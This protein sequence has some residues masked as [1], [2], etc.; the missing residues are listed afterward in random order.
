MSESK[1]K[2]SKSELIVVE[3]IEAC[4]DHEIAELLSG[5]HE[6]K[7]YLLQKAW[8]KCVSNQTHMR[9]HKKELRNCP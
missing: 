2:L 3:R 6:T 8:S 4:S 1:T 5:N 9:K 7:K